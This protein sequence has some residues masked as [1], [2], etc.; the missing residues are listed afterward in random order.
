MTEV[1]LLRGGRIY[2]PGIANATALVVAGGTVA[3]VGADAAALAFCDGATATSVDLAGT[4]VTPA[5]VDAHVHTTSTGLALTGLDVT[6]A[7]SLAETL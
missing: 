1:T 4:L 7:G 5:F 3:F 2:T 6:T